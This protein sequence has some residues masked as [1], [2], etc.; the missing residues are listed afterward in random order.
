MGIVN[1]TIERDE[2]G[3]YTY[4]GAR[5]ST[6][7]DYVLGDRKG[8]DKKIRSGRGGRF[9]SLSVNSKDGR[10]MKGKRRK[11]EGGKRKRKK[12]VE[13]EMG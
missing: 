9:R 2:E 7:I 11:R 12:F 6:V 13:R 4:T 8:E 5:R 10:R 3:E 1:G